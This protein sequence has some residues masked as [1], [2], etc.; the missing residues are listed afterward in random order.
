MHTYRYSDLRHTSYSSKECFFELAFNNTHSHLCSSPFGNYHTKKGGTFPCIKESQ[1][2]CGIL[3]FLGPYNYFSSVLITFQWE[4]C[5]LSIYCPGAMV[6]WWLPRGYL[7]EKRK[8]DTCSS[9]HMEAQES[10]SPEWDW[11]EVPQKGWKLN[12]PGRMHGIQEEKGRRLAVLQ[13]KGLF[14]VC[15]QLS[16]SRQ[17]CPHPEESSCAGAVR[18]GSVIQGGFSSAAYMAYMVPPL[19]WFPWV[20]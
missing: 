4:N 2:A 11:G 17:Q 13:S 10:N 16:Y 14:R 8:G 7:K 18:Y 19:L 1:L 6:I 15:T 20:S 5:S 3:L 9:G 12:R